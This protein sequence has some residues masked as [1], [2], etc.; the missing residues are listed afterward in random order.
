MGPEPPDTLEVFADTVGG[1][2]V[3]SAVLQRSKYEHVGS[4]KANSCCPQVC[5]PLS[6]DPGGVFVVGKPWTLASTTSVEHN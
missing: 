5:V 3:L 4:P 1:Q 6:L 2:S